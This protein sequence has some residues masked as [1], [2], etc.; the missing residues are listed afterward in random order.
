MKHI[1][2][3]LGDGGGGGGGVMSSIGHLKHHIVFF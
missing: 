1:F 2:K 3:L